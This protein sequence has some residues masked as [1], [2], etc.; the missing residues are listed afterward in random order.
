VDEIYGVAS[1]AD[2]SRVAA[3]VTA[4]SRTS[5][6]LRRLMD[7]DELQR[8]WEEFG[9][10]DPLWAILTDPGS[11]SGQWDVDEF[12][13][14]GEDTIGHILRVLDEAGATVRFDGRALDF[15]CGVGR[16][17]RALGGRFA[18]AVGVDV[19]P[20]MVER[21]RELNADVPACSF[22]VN[23]RADL[24]RFGDGQFALVFS[25]L[26]LQHIGA[27]L[28]ETY[29]REFFRV[30]QPG[31][32]VVFQLPSTKVEP[33][34]VPT[35]ARRA[36]IRVDGAPRRVHPGQ[37]VPLR[38][39]VEHRG[40]GDWSAELDP[41]IR[42]GNRWFDRGGVLV[43]D[44][45]RCALPASVAPGTSFDV[46]LRMTAP[47]RPGNYVL[48]VDLVQEG[49]AWF[50]PSGS[51]P[52]RVP[53]VVGIDSPAAAGRWVLDHLGPLTPH[54]RRAASAIK[55]RL[56]GAPPEPVAQPVMEMHGIP[57]ER[58]AAIVADAGGTL[59]RS[60]LHP[61]APGWE[62]YLYYAVSDG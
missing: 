14:S 38:V 2:S 21:A 55:R 45:A 58:V 56:S 25:V 43:A 30:A 31:G 4:R 11:R 1:N 54:A 46:V 59:L 61:S 15:G 35:A 20:S 49:V 3:G 17:T 7:F 62:S 9:R 27:E 52:A 22:V 28:A 42:V 33:A 44:D 50:S 12:F 10:S 39:S 36:A 60:D 32:A 29:L 18:E 51:P 37:V 13:A 8:N 23:D 6:R 41:P 48:D 5:R 40:D 19:A 26:V 34:A 53:M 57:H 16:V 24:T 47:A